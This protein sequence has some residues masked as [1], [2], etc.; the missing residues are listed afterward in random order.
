MPKIDECPPIEEFALI[1]ENRLPLKEREEVLL[2]IA[3]CN[4]CAMGYSIFT[5]FIDAE[6][7]KVTDIGDT[8]FESAPRACDVKSKPG[9]FSRYFI[10]KVSAIV[11]LIGA[12]FLCGFSYARGTHFSIGYHENVHIGVEQKFETTPLYWSKLD[13]SIRQEYL[14]AQAR[15]I[16][17]T[18]GSNHVLSVK[19]IIKLKDEFDKRVSE[20]VSLSN[21]NIDNVLS[22]NDL[23]IIAMTSLDVR[24]YADF[25]KNNRVTELKKAENWIRFNQSDYLSIASDYG[26]LPPEVWEQYPVNDES[27]KTISWIAG[28]PEERKEKILMLSPDEAIQ[29]RKKEE[30]NVPVVNPN[31]NR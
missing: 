8:S 18:G 5:S 15:K 9:R 3:N 26:S 20:I 7:D 27:L 29:E 21:K 2:H 10:S 12:S 30:Q 6:K 28:L 24:I 1:R 31:W 13:D 16:L 4:E 23:D 25:L 14:S 22:V 19:D 17:G 11:L